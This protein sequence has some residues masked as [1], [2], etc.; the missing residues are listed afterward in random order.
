MDEDLRLK[1]IVGENCFPYNP[2]RAEEFFHHLQERYPD[3]SD[4]IQTAVDNPEDA[5]I[6][7]PLPDEARALCITAYQNAETISSIGDAPAALRPNL[8]WLGST[9]MSYWDAVSETVFR[10]DYY[11]KT[12][13]PHLREA[14]NDFLS[15]YFNRLPSPSNYVRRTIQ[16]LPGLGERSAM[17]QPSETTPPLLE[18]SARCENDAEW[19]DSPLT[20]SGLPF[21]IPLFYPS[22]YSQPPE[23]PKETITAAF[24]II[25]AFLAPEQLIA[26]LHPGG[27]TNDFAI[28]TWG[29]A[30]D[31]AQD[32]ADDCGRQETLGYGVYNFDNNSISLDFLRNLPPLFRVGYAT[33]A[34]GE[35]EGLW[36]L[37]DPKIRAVLHEFS[38]KIYY[39]FIVHTEYEDRIS[40]FYQWSYRQQSPSD[41]MGYIPYPMPLS[42]EAAFSE[43]TGRAHVEI[44]FD[45]DG[46]LVGREGFPL[47]PF[48]PA[49]N[50]EGPDVYSRYDTE[51]F[52]AEMLT[53]YF[54][55]KIF[56]FDLEG[57]FPAR[58]AR[59]RIIDK[60]L[61][62]GFVHP[63]AFS[64]ESI[65]SEF[66]SV[67]IDYEPIEWVGEMRLEGFMNT[68]G[69]F[70]AELYGG[71]R[72]LGN[73]LAFGVGIH[74]RYG[75]ELP[76]DPTGAFE[77]EGSVRFNNIFSTLVYLTFDVELFARAGAKFEG[78]S[79][80]PLMD[81]GARMAINFYPND[82]QG[83]HLI[84]GGFEELD[85]LNSSYPFYGTL[86]LGYTF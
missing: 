52:F 6:S 64:A 68:Y 30:I 48:E 3:Y 13:D 78:G 58:L 2:S 43:G 15:F 8:A 4:E 72:T 14:F 81:V 69:V 57:R 17:Y 9:F 1:L 10:N 35:T 49:S 22:R 39:D 41:R 45:R 11:N 42:Q 40:E 33:E 26:M 71:M 38:H 82:A 29:S 12:I 24:E 7:S 51:E 76:Y 59:Q 47:P 32:V 62:G 84:L 83:L 56:Q 36:H 23:A 86:G 55:D 85:F 28:F 46:N 60:F 21:A 66:E 20:I 79:F 31:G 70:G 67:G 77:L 63:E 44:G 61:A 34:N 73:D 19:T 50:D 16:D 5:G 65:R 54:Y 53:E 75:S 80:G 74:F 18:N 25:K 27:G 37:I